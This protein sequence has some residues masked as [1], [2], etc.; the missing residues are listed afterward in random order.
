MANTA[1]ISAGLP[2]AKN[3]GQSPTA[4]VNTAYVSAGLPA[5]PIYAAT[6]TLETGGISAAGY[7]TFTAEQP[8]TNRRRR[9]LIISGAS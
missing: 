5:S 7:G 1:Y 9:F 8:T 6:G 3:S 2:I 4:G